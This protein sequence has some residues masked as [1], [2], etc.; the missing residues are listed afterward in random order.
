[1]IFPMAVA[2]SLNQAA[3]FLPSYLPQ[4]Y[5]LVPMPDLPLTSCTGMFI[6][7][8]LIISTMYPTH[9]HTTNAG[10][11]RFQVRSAATKMKMFQDLLNLSENQR[12]D[13]HSI[14]V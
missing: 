4:F 10:C 9:I 12:K 5:S 13:M 1:M 8:M 14:S 6:H 2:L 7:T 11:H 3:D